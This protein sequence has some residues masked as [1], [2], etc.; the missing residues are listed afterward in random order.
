[1]TGKTNT[2]CIVHSELWNLASSVYSDLFFGLSKSGAAFKQQISF[3]CLPSEDF[4]KSPEYKR[5]LMERFCDGVIFNTVFSEEECCRVESDLKKVSLPM[6]WLNRKIKFNSIYPDEESAANSLAEKL[7]KNGHEK[8][9]YVGVERATHYSAEVRHLELKETFLKM[10][11]KQFLAIDRWET[12]GN[13][14]NLLKAFF[15]APQGTTAVV[16]YADSLI[17]QMFQTAGECGVFSPAVI[18][19]QSLM[20]LFIVWGDRADSRMMR[21]RRPCWNLDRRHLNEFLRGF[22]WADKIFR[23]SQFLL[24]STMGIPLRTSTGKELAMQI[25]QRSKRGYFFYDYRTFSCSC[26]SFHSCFSSSSCAW[27]SPCKGLELRVSQQSETDRA[28]FRPVHRRQRRLSHLQRPL[29]G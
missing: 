20:H 11:G 1:M 19:G 12:Q 3:L 13:L 9:L 26:S 6:L 28:V 2:I 23:R 29:A 27:E 25:L 24:Q 18:H 17:P 8:I 7:R 16:L 5:L 14:L 4:F 21:R 15:H 10:G 22:S